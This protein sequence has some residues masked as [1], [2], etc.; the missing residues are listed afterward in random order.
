[1]LDRLKITSVLLNCIK[2]EIFSLDEPNMPLCGVNI[3][4]KI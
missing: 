4:V 2:H 1:M 3:C